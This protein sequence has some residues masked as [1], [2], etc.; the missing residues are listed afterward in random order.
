MEHQTCVVCFEELPC[1][2]TEDI[3][4]TAK[5]T[6]GEIAQYVKQYLVDCET[7]QFYANSNTIIDFPVATRE[8]HWISQPCGHCIHMNCAIT[9]SNAQSV[10]DKYKGKCLKCFFPLPMLPSKQETFAQYLYRIIVN[11]RPYANELTLFYL[12]HFNRMKQ[13][14]TSPESIET[15]KLMIMAIIRLLLVA[16]PI[17]LARMGIQGILKNYGWIAGGSTRRSTRRRRSSKRKSLRR[18]SSK[19]QY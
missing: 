16:F 15:Y 11:L 9:I 7:K 5:T 14:M 2:E 17:E 13:E 8:Q 6:P 10:G 19:R 4:I 12:A 1:M 3:R 18:R